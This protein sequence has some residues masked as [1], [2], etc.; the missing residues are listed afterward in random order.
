ML[1]SFKIWICNFCSYKIC[2]M[3]TILN[4]EVFV[5][6]LLSKI[7]TVIIRIHKIKCVLSNNSKSFY[8]I[9]LNLYWKYIPCWLDGNYVKVHIYKMQIQINNLFDNTTLTLH[10]VCVCNCVCTY[11]YYIYPPK[12]NKWELTKLF[13]CGSVKMSSILSLTLIRL[14]QLFK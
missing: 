8:V 12:L 11:K 2:Y 3:F 10:R 7:A 6:S 13:L 14:N 1:Y 4:L 9:L 5:F